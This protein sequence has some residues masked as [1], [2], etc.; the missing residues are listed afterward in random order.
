[1]P[2]CCTRWYQRLKSMYNRKIFCHWACTGPLTPESGTHNHASH[3][4][5]MQ[6][7][8]S[9]VLQVTSPSGNN[10]CNVLHHGILIIVASILGGTTGSNYVIYYLVNLGVMLWAR[11]S[12]CNFG[13]PKYPVKLIMTWRELIICGLPRPGIYGLCIGHGAHNSVDHWL[14]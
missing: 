11:F 9:Q 10:R 13:P 7:V 5:Y 6:Y 2:N 12:H 1:M 14:H 3:L 8:A 4:M